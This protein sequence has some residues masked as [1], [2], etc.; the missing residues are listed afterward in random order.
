MSSTE[1]MD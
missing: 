1:L